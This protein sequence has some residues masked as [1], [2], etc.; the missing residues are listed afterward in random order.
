MAIPY[1]IPLLAIWICWIGA[2]CLGKGPAKEFHWDWHKVEG[3]GWESISQSN[4]ISVKERGYLI[5]LVASQHR[6]SRIEIKSEQDLQELA[7]QTR[8]K[9]VD[10][11][12]KGVQE[13]LAQSADSDLCSPTGN[14]ESWVF[15]RNGETDS[16]ILHSSFA[17]T[18]TIQPTLTNGFHDLVLAMHGSAT[19]QT[20][21][22]YRFDGSKYRVTACYEA[23]WEINEKDGSIRDSKE[24]RITP[25]AGK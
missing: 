9:A 24:P 17:Q 14:C 23:N 3:D 19:E 16:V 12:G 1:R 22:L 6:R 11:N 7:G 15:R 5:S 4:A 10:L 13:F 21:R 20:L 2:F 8:I 25:C 18:F